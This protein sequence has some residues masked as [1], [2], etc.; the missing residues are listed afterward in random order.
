M[1]D[2]A[3]VGMIAGYG[4][5]PKIA[6][7]VLRA[8]GLRVVATAVH[9]E[10][11]QDLDS[12]V[13]EILWLGAG[14]LKSGLKFFKKHGVESLIMAGKVRKIH[15]FKNFKP[16]TKAIS[17]LWK[18]P[19]YRD[20]T[21]LN[22]IADYFESNGIP[23]LSQVECD[24]AMVAREG[25]I[26]GGK[27]DKKALESAQFGFGQAKAIAGLDIGQTIVVERK[28]V[29]AVEAIEGTDEAIRRGG[30]LGSGKAVVIKVA[31]PGQDPRFD[32]PAVGPDTI[33]EMK[34]H[35]CRLLAVEAD[36]T[37]LLDRERL[38]EDAERAGIQVVALEGRDNDK[39]N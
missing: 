37:L 25:V 17:I 30:S 27:T 28:A 16:D 10:A 38:I 19:D 12:H 8:R 22:A 18:L 1:T 7:K 31:K 21:I 39:R 36:W 33:E 23:L 14:Q 5:F 35:G 20:D 4:C 3:C 11:D 2:S 13:D 34:E 24:P 15:L 26:A 29:L 32:V 9:G 6:A